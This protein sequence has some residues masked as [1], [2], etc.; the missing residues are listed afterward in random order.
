MTYKNGWTPRPWESMDLDL[1]PLNPWN[2]C[3]FFMGLDSCTL[4]QSMPISRSIQF[5]YLSPFSDICHHS[6]SHLDVAFWYRL[7]Q[8]QQLQ[9][10]G[11]ISCFARL[12]YLLCSGREVGEMIFHVSSQDCLSKL[13]SHLETQLEVEAPCL[14]TLRSEERRVGKECA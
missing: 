13:E 12:A 14:G 1:K 5:G 7:H 6:K 4:I 10:H 9:L 8:S 11:K 2:G 3:G